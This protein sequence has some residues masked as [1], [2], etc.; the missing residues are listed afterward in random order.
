MGIC[1]MVWSPMCSRRD[2]SWL[3]LQ[4]AVSRDF[5]V[6]VVLVDCFDIVLL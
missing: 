4:P 6:I 2:R 3:C 5:V 1:I